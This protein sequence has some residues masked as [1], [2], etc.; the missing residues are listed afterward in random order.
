MNDE[1]YLVVWMTTGETDHFTVFQSYSQAHQ[2][3]NHLIDQDDTYTA[4]ICVPIKST[5][6][7]T[8]NRKTLVWPEI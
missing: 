7:S 6:Y 5:D 8:V 1:W 4:S 3:Y 2:L